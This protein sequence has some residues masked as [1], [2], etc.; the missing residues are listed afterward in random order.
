MPAQHLIFSVLCC[1]LASRIISAG[2]I[3]FERDILPILQTHC[4][5]CHGPEVQEAN[6]RLDDLSINLIE[7]RAVTESW[8]EV[9]NVLQAGEMPPKDE[10]QLS[11][12]ELS[13]VT[14]WVSN[15]IKAALAARQKTDGRVV[16]R[17][18]NRVEYQHTMQDLLGLEMDYARDLPPDA[19]SADDFRNN[20]SSLQMSSLQL[21]YYL[22]TARR[23]M[24]RVIVQGEQAPAIDHTFTAT[25][26][27][28]WLGDPHRV[29]GTVA[30][31]PQCHSA[32]GCRLHHVERA[33]GEAL[34]HQGCFRSLVSSCPVI[35]GVASRR[36]LESRQYPIEQFFGSRFAPGATSGL[37]P[38]STAERPS[39]TATAKCTL[40]GAGQP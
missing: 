17:R 6:V 33:D 26:I 14:D 23:A 10:P 22:A 11:G 28:N 37:D 9:L 27:D 40:T 12:N 8:H 35:A 7:D 2:E 16:L 31:E 1:G 18:L 29:C 13:T 21:E 34:W 38:R 3:Q 15:S 5:R 20:G 19:M 25:S 30:R 36:P 32:I 39:G 4:I 24:D